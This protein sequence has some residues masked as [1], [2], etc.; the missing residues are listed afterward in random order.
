LGGASVKICDREPATSAL[1]RAF[2]RTPHKSPIEIAA[3]PEQMMQAKLDIEGLMERLAI[4]RSEPPAT[5]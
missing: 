1:K 2:F 4:V 3:A 5:R